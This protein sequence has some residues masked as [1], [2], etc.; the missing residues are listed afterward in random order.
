MR[1]CIA[2]DSW[3]LAVLPVHDIS[4]TKCQAVVRRDGP[5]QPTSERGAYRRFLLLQGRVLHSAT[6]FVSDP[7]PGYQYNVHHLDSLYAIFS[8]YTLWR[9]IGGGYALSW[10]DSLHVAFPSAVHVLCS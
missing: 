6:D 8:A 4:G 7:I 3:A 10:Q 5:L 2:I 9:L 1:G